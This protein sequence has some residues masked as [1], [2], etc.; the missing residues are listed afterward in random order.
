LANGNVDCAVSK[1]TAEP[2]AETLALY[3]EYGRRDSGR[4]TGLTPIGAP[5][6]G[7]AART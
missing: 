6:A 1:A 3:A 5:P 7:A 4:T 2:S